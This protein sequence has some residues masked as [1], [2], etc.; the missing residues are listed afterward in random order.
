VEC[1]LPATLTYRILA[2]DANQAAD[3]AKKASPNGVKYRLIGKRDI[4]LQVF[5]AG[6]SF[7]RFAKNLLG[8]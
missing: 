8:G 5:Y 7:L 3:L 4:K 1:L 2:E 6:S